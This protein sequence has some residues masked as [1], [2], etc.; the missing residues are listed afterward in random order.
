MENKQEYLQSIFDLARIHHLCRSQKEFAD[1][2][3]VSRSALSSALNGVEAYLTDNLLFK[4][5]L[6]AKDHGLEPTK[7][8]L[9]Q[10]PQGP[11]VFIP[12]ETRAMFDNMAETIRIQA[13]MLL[14]YQ[15]GFAP[16]AGGVFAPK[17]SR[18]DN[19]K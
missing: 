8:A 2:V 12:E 9:A 5:Q 18:L 1:L 10:Q 17:N 3:G 4:V 14:Q 6:F 13:Q 11:G 19:N 7:A 16:A 15:A